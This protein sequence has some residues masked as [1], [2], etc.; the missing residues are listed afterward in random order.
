MS[1]PM[2]ELLFAN[3][4]DATT[5]GYLLDP[6]T[7]E[8]LRALIAGEEKP[9]NSSELR[10]KTQASFPLKEGARPE[11]L[12]EAGWGV[13]F[14]A[15]TDPKVRDALAPL[16]ELRKQQAGAVNPNYYKEFFGPDGYRPGEDKNAFLARHGAAPGIV[17]PDMGVPYYLLLVGDPNTI[18]FRFQ[19]QLD[20]Q[21]GVG[22]IYF[23]TVD[24]YRCYA[25]SVVAAETGKVQLPRQA[26]FFGVRNPDDVSTNLSADNLI[27]PL[28]SKMGA[29]ADY[30]SWNFPTIMDGD[31]T[32]TRLNKLL[33][34]A[35]TPA[36]LFTA[37]HGMG[38]PT[39]DAD[40]QLARQGALLCSD[41]QG[42]NRWKQAISTDFYFT[43]DDLDK[44]ARLLGVIAFFFA[45]YGAGTP[46]FDEFAHAGKVRKEIAPKNFLA[47]LPMKM[48]AHPNGGAL[49]VIG[50]VERAWGY[51][52][53]WERSGRTL[54]SFE[55]AFKKLFANKPIGFATEAFNLR[56]AELASDLSVSL[57]ELKW[58]PTAIDP[59]LLAGQWTASNDTRGYVV[60]GDPAV[61]LVPAPA[62][63]T[64]PER[65]LLSISS[66]TSAAAGS[67][68]ASFESPPPAPPAP[69]DSSNVSFGWFNSG[70]SST[71]TDE[72]APPDTSLADT[73]QKFAIKLGESLQQAIEDATVLEVLT[74]VSSDLA[75]VTYKDG[76]F[77]GATPRAVTRIALDGDTLLCV[78]ERDGQLDERLWSIHLNMVERAQ[79]NRIEMIRAAADAAAGLIKAIRS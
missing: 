40:V 45:C 5:G 43:G 35:E 15:N 64:P 69:G 6:L 20:V 14:A 75:S 8:Q 50:H 60:L 57:E 70:S 41:W 19:Y 56:Y 10:F 24:E 38:F 25:E 30:R 79:A 17:D 51:S 28:S 36:M 34:G 47:R 29:N 21:F 18:P 12:E 16:L 23:D 68:Q 53:M 11:A 61:R 42:P 78:P 72:A 76:R 2:T 9:E 3:G 48:L 27:K 39:T 62:G 55:D 32:K 65:A 52:F 33:G 46:K 4:I 54:T 49:A 74:Y 66:G 73:L 59:L 26:S 37:S 13:I 1:D 77:E 67:A 22:R 7:P 31:A 44:D 63:A 71:A 58:D